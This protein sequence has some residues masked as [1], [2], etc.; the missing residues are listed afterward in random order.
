MWKNPEAIRY[1]IKSSSKPDPDRKEVYRNKN[2]VT[3]FRNFLFPKKP[4]HF[5]GRYT[6]SLL[7]II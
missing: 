5:S 4:H 1:R 7:K 3:I 6:D 2:K